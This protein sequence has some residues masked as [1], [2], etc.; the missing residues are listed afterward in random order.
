MQGTWCRTLEARHHLFDHGEI[1]DLPITRHGDEELGVGLTQDKL[2]LLSL[3]A[4]I[5]RDDGGTDTATGKPRQN[6]VWLVGQPT[7][8]MVTACDT[9]TQ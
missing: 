6:P 7:R 4:R 3:I 8:N 2:D 5:D 9:E 1:I